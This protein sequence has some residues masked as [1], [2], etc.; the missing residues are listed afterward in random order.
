MRTRRRRLPAVV[1]AVA[2]AVV[3]AVALPATAVPPTQAFA[4]LTS[5]TAGSLDGTGL[6]VTGCTPSSLGTTDLS[7]AEFVPPGPATQ[8]TVTC[9]TDTGIGVSLAEARDGLDLYL[10]GLTHPA[11]LPG[12]YSITTDAAGPLTIASGF[13]SATL[14]GTTLTMPIDSTNSGVIH[15]AGAV[16]SVVLTEGSGTFTATFTLGTMHV[17]PT[18]TTTST[19]L[20]PAAVAGAGASAV[21]PAF[22]C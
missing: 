4:D 1:A 12:V 16:T 3:L 6:T 8:P 11:C 9:T 13:S 5:A 22:T 19:T 7:G 2:V 21:T 18:T 20:D 15:L 17:E 14:V 10:V